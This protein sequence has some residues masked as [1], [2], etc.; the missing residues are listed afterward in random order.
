MEFRTKLGLHTPK[1]SF[2]NNMVIYAKAWHTGSCLCIRKGQLVLLI[3]AKTFMRNG[4]GIFIFQVQVLPVCYAKNTYCQNRPFLTSE[5]YTMAFHKA[6]PS[7]SRATQ[8]QL[9]CLLEAPLAYRRLAQY[10]VLFTSG[11]EF[12]IQ[13]LSTWCSF[14]L[15]AHT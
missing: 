12:R 11:L 2:H 14:P 9:M 1:E 6:A 3:P 5:Y 8:Q 15:L 13:P 4:A 10:L 7:L